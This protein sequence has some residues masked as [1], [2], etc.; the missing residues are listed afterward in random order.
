MSENL[1]IAV[2]LA[3]ASDLA[4]IRNSWLRNYHE[5]GHLSHVPNDVFFADAGHWGVVDRCLRSNAVLVATPEGD[6]DSILG[7]VCAGP[8]ALHYAYVKAP[9][10]R[11]GILSRLLG[12]VPGP[13]T[14]CTHW[15]P[16]VRDWAAHGHAYT[17]NPY[18]LE[19]AP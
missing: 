13:L 5:H 8:D 17:F 11:L 15:T 1:P 4:F 14:V 2:R 6:D 7:W 9:F 3:R 18:L 12:S 10:R 16:V 19:R